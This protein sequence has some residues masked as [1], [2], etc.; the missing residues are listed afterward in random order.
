MW[1]IALSIISTSLSITHVSTLTRELQLR[2]EICEMNKERQEKETNRKSCQKKQNMKNK[3]CI[4][5]KK[6]GLHSH[7]PQ[8]QNCCHNYKHGN[9]DILIKPTGVTN[10][11][12]H[13]LINYN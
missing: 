4:V 1:G 10:E 3:T 2:R 13:D 5:M 7:L 6:S 8:S 9:A 12:N 11:S